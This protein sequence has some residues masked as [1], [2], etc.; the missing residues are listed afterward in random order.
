M[1]VADPVACKGRKDRLGQQSKG[2]RGFKAP[3]GPRV[4]RGLKHKANLA[5]LVPP[6][7]LYP[8]EV[9]NTPAHY[10]QGKLVHRDRKDTLALLVQTGK[11]ADQ[12]LLDHQE[13]MAKMAE[14]E[15]KV[16]TVALELMVD[17]GRLDVTVHR[18]HKGPPDR[19]GRLGQPDRLD[20]LD[21]L[22]HWVRKVLKV[23][24]VLKGRMDRRVRRVRLVLLVRLAYLVPLV[25]E[26]PM[27]AE[28]GAI[29]DLGATE[30]QGGL[31]VIRGQ[32][33]MKVLEA[34]LVDGKVGVQCVHAMGITAMM[35]D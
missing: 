21:R 27:V 12:D 28:K 8:I 16:A 29:P 2:P 15:E 3:K 19:L 18:V 34:I 23:Q 7:P 30:V 10:T 14:M 20:R 22:D 24:K 35:I 6:A 1:G 32:E 9:K 4:P 11:W 5:N 25:K 33:E 13:E 17:Q 26:V 31:R